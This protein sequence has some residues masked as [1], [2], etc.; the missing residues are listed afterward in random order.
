MQTLFMEGGFPMWFLLVFGLGTLA[1]AG[2]FAW[3]PLRRT[4]RITLALGAATFFTTWTGVAS[5]FATV[6]H[7]AVK[8]HQAHPDLAFVEVVLQGAAESLA[9]AILGFTML[10]LA[11]L[12][13]ALG[14]H[15]EVTP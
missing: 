2:R 14:F 15:R 3:A 10:S 4:L 1:L 5:A 13:V 8:F 9:P 12:L 11:G 6:G 7:N